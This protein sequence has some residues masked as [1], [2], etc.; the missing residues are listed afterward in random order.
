MPATEPFVFDDEPLSNPTFR[1]RQ[2]DASL[3]ALSPRD[4]SSLDDNESFASRFRPNPEFQRDLE[5]ILTAG[6]EALLDELMTEILEDARQGGRGE[7][8]QQ[9]HC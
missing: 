1:G 5:W 8:N 2:L 3:T 7:L 9:D 6:N 4:A